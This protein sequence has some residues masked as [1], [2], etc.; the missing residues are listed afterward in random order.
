M[1]ELEKLHCYKSINMLI[2]SCSA[3]F[4]KLDDGF[5]P[6]FLDSV[7]NSS[8]LFTGEAEVDIVFF[9]GILQKLFQ[10]P[11]YDFE[12]ARFWCLSSTYSD[13]LVKRF[14]LPQECVSIIPRNMLFPKSTSMTPFSLSNGS[15]FI[16]AGRISAS[17]NITAIL[18]LVSKL[19]VKHGI[20]IELS[21][22][23]SF[24]DEQNFDERPQFRKSYKELFFD[25]LN[26]LE[27]TSKPIFYGEVD[28]LDWPN[29]SKNNSIFINLSKYFQED[30]GVSLAQW[31]ELGR[32]SLISNW[33]GHQDIHS[34]N[35]IKIPPH[36]IPERDEPSHIVDI[37][38]EQLANFV[39]NP[40][41][42]SFTSKDL[43][44]KVIIP[45]YC[46]KKHVTDK[47]LK[48]KNEL[49]HLCGYIQ[50]GQWGLFSSTHQG[51]NFLNSIKTFFNKSAFRKTDA[52]IICNW[53]ECDQRFETH[54]VK[55]KII[56]LSAEL[57]D[58]DFIYFRD[59]HLA[60]NLRK[61]MMT[62]KIIFPYFITEMLDT[63]RLVC[64]DN[65]VFPPLVIILDP[66]QQFLFAKLNEYTRSIDRVII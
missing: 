9:G 2:K 62:K 52:A 5:K 64:K 14:N 46:S 29:K 8:S 63:V 45:K 51:Q 13:I 37:K 15:H 3:F 49:G 28:A 66:S 7:D 10:L 56:Q 12:R 32:P 59:I 65:D 43:D 26:E 47:I 61:M 30:F 50:N 23:G 18:K 58:V 19:Q 20:P 1:S 54:K 34:E 16:Y 27:W 25:T 21:I 60:E 35:V 33:G 44:S 40:V 36:L 24:D 17:K 48:I 41:S 31:E 4:D 22:Y 57:N 53:F 42:T 39:L 6:I 55:D 38:I 11:S